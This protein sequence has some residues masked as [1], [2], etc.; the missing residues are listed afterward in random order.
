MNKISLKQ[1]REVEEEETYQK[2]V[3]T[4]ETEWAKKE[5]KGVIKSGKGRKKVKT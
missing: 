5:V 2:I 4:L 1:Q 3:K